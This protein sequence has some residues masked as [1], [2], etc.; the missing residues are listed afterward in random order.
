MFL[1][2][3]KWM[4]T[5]IGGLLTELRSWLSLRLGPWRSSAEAMRERVVAPLDATG[6]NAPNVAYIGRH[7]AE[8]RFYAACSDDFDEDIC[9]CP[10][11]Q[12]AARDAAAWARRRHAPLRGTP[13]SGPAVSARRLVE[14]ALR[15]RPC[16]EGRPT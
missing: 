16:P 7:N 11:C 1:N 3:R 15:P 5:T 13:A 9:G 2:A 6:S 10:V 4:S 12:H 14:F 8:G